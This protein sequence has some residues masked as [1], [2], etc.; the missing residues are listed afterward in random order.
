MTTTN[1]PIDKWIF[2]RHNFNK[3]NNLIVLFLKI[4]YRSISLL[5][6]YYLCIGKK[7]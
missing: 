1:I 7:I 5:L 3:K 6:F 2:K 4:I